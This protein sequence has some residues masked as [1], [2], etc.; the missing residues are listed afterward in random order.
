MKFHL[1]LE[2]TPMHYAAMKNLPTCVQ[3]SNLFFFAYFY[4]KK[5]YFNKFKKFI[6][7]SKSLVSH[8]AYLF[9]E[10]Q[11]R[12]TPCDLAERFGHKDIALYLESKMIFSVSW[13]EIFFLE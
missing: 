12:S 13:I 3:V 1:K 8:G 10:N 4:L 2:N 7:F 9:V 5:K 11:D 6:L